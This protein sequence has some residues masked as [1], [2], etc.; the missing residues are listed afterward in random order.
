M[1][2]IVP[3]KEK[4]GDTQHLQECDNPIRQSKQYYTNK[5]WPVIQAN[6]SN[7]L[8]SQCYCAVALKIVTPAKRVGKGF[9]HDS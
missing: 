6:I 1:C 9:S 8:S 5:S 3:E 7:N 4:A 2:H